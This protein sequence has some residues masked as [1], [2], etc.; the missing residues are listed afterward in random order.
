MLKKVSFIVTVLLAVVIATGCNARKVV[1]KVL[2]DNLARAPY[3]VIIVPGIG[4][5]T[6]TQRTNGF[7]ARVNWAKT[8]YDR[9]VAR[10]IIFSGAACS[11][12]YIEGKVMKMIA[13]K[14][15]VPPQHVFCETQAQHTK[16]NV[17]YCWL[18]ARKMGFKKIAVATDPYQAYFIKGFIHKN[19][20]EMGILPIA[21]DSL[22]YYSPILPPVAFDSAR[23]DN[24]VPLSE[25]ESFWVRFK[26]ANSNK[27]P[28]SPKIN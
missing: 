2:N 10:N 27:L 23:V 25:R 5:D 11:S 9:G 7:N 12:P 28:A 20:P 18:M 6:A 14:M 21:I 26:Y 1:I 22:Q 13:E 3:D 15:G 4:F 19:M 24:F 8:L 16:E 17:Y